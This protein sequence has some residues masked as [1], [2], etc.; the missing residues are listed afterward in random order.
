MST[1]SNQATT[2]PQASFGTRFMS[3]LKRMTSKLRR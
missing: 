3:Y 1:T 2:V